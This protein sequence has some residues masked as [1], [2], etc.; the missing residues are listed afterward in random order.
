MRK[1][2]KE[3]LNMADI[4]EQAGRL[5]KYVANS[6]GL[7]MT[8]SRDFQDCSQKIF[9]RT[10]INI[11]VST[12]KRLWGY[13]KC[14]ENYTPSPYTLD[15]L[16]KSVGYK[17]FKTFCQKRTQARAKER[18]QNSIARMKKDLFGLQEELEKLEALVNL[19]SN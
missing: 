16:S 9:E 17:N 14:A 10:H 7:E 8:T 2:R 18:A 15:V 11:S 6:F 5:R 13:V 1:N 4:A 3:Q 19:S 12:L